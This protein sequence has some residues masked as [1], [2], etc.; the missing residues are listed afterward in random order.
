MSGAT[1]DWTFPQA[2]AIRTA[3]PLTEATLSQ[4]GQDTTLSQNGTI[5]TDAIPQ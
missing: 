4:L 1:F 3:P 5:K 2:F